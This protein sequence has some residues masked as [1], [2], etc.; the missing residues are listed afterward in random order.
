MKRC[1]FEPLHV[2]EE[3]ITGIMMY[4]HNEFKIDLKMELA[5]GGRDTD[6]H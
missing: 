4:G 2:K 5:E 3:I 1:N 6:S